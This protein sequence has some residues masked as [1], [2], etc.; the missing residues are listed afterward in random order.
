MDF[1]PVRHILNTEKVYGSMNLFL[2][3]LEVSD[4]QNFRHNDFKN[5]AR[6]VESKKSFRGIPCHCIFPA[7]IAEK[8]FGSLIFSFSDA[9]DR[10]RSIEASHRLPGIFR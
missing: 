2:A 4:F 9:I 8:T 1:Y 5:F 6:C 3:R 10:M 7:K